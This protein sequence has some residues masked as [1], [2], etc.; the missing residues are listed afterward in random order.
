MQAGTT[1]VN[2]NTGESL[3]MIVSEEDNDGARQPYEV[4][5]PPRRLLQETAFGVA[6]TVARV[7]G[8]EEKL[9]K[10]VRFR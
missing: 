7:A 9:R 3:T 1:I 4:H 6:A 5:L 8:I 2:K 10:Y